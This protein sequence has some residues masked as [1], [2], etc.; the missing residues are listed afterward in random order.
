MARVTRSLRAV[1]IAMH[2]YHA[3][4]GHLPGPAILDKSGKSLLSWRVEL[5]PYLGHGDLHGQFKLDEPWDSEHNRKLLARMP[6]LYAHPSDKTGE[7]FLTHYRV[8]A[9]PA[10]TPP[11]TTDLFAPIFRFG[12]LGR[13]GLQRL[14][15]V[16]IRTAPLRVTT[17]TGAIS[18]R[19]RRWLWPPW[20]GPGEAM[21]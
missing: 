1:V 3:D 17:S 16:S 8:F 4:N 2:N 21:A 12:H 7:R 14:L 19:R 15:V 5:L 10:M 11:G 20:R 18:R 13:V 9:A 6:P